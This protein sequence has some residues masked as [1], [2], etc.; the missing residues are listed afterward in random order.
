VN[1]RPGSAP[2]Y[3]ELAS[4][5]IYTQSDPIGLAGGINT[6]AYVGGNP[7]SFVDPEGLAGYE[8]LGTITRHLNQLARAQGDS[9]WTSRSY[10]AERA[11][12]GR[13]QRGEE[14]PYD[15]AF[16]RHELAEAQQCQPALAGPLDK[17]VDAQQRA[18]RS[19]E[20]A[21]GNTWSDRYH[22]DVIRRLPDLF[23]PRGP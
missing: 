14:T 5:G 12:M 3:G 21:Q 1:S 13:L 11:M 10:A 7:I 2:W 9:Y 8:G 16:Y 23:Y 17:Y 19:V 20:R 6:Y 4:G 15:V 18:H 22:P